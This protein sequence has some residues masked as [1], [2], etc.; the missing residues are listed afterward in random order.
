[1]TSIV[2][3]GSSFISI[4]QSLINF[5]AGFGNVHSKSFI[6]AQM[7]DSVEYMV[8]SAFLSGHS[9]QKY[10][11]YITAAK[12]L[13]QRPN[14]LNNIDMVDWREKVSRTLGIS[15][16]KDG[17]FSFFRIVKGPLLVR[18]ASEYARNPAKHNPFQ[19]S[20]FYKSRKGSFAQVKWHLPGAR[21]NQKPFFFNIPSHSLFRNQDSNLDH[22][23]YVLQY[24]TSS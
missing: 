12:F 8:L 1:M 4:L 17:I 2:R 16:I 15:H 19:D 20:S 22:G 23:T 5:S 3:R 13:L 10:Q 24:Q 7:M 18:A 21:H 14:I 9:L 11:R 6:T